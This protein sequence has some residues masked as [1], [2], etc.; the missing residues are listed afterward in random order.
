MFEV[1]LHPILVGTFTGV[2]HEQKLLFQDQPWTSIAQHFGHPKGQPHSARQKRNQSDRPPNRLQ[3][4]MTSVSSWHSKITDACPVCPHLKVRAAWRG[5]ACRLNAA[6]NT[7]SPSA[8][9]CKTERAALGPRLWLIKQ[10][11][12]LGRE[13][14]YCGCGNVPGW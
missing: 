2:P 1:D 6:S 3:K 11:P 7:G 4:E 8:I 5:L 12:R 13:Q 9:Y 14:R 10:K